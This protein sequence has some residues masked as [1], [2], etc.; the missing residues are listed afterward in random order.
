MRA[1][2]PSTR[3]VRP[4]FDFVTLL[5][6]HGFAVAPDQTRTFVEAVGILGPRHMGDIHG[7]ALATLAP[8]PERRP[9]FDALFGLL[10]LGQTLSAPTIGE[11]DDDEDLKAVD[12]DDGATEPPKPTRSARSGLRPL[13][14]RPWRSAGSAS[15]TRPR[16]C[17]ASPAPPRPA[18]R[19]RHPTGADPPRPGTAGTC[20]ASCATPSGAT[21]RC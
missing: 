17:D 15:P 13:R 19:A 8:P 1:P 4:F 18:C 7:A 16:R 2:D 3:G 20:V 5:R 6:R 11:P 10:F 12:E 14:A 21:G 9:E